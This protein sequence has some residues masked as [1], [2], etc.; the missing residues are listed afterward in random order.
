MSDLPISLLPELLASALTQNA[1]F[2]VAQG[3]TTYRIK[4]S[5]LSPFPQAYGLFTQTGTTANISGVTEQSIIDGGLG[6]L[7]V[8]ANQFQVGD[9]FHAE[10]KGHLSNNNDFLQ[11]RVKGDSVVLADSSSIQ[12]NTSGDDTLFTLDIYFVIRQVGSASIAS[13]LTKGFLRTVKNSNFSVNGYSFE[14]ENNSTFD[15]TIANTLDITIQF[16]AADP[17][18][19]IYTDFFVLN[20]I[21]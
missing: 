6:T 12:Y 21:Y 13:I 10:I 2:A 20:K 19:Y 9:T 15:T 14:S 7:S 4:N 5:N 17:Q 8:G 18:T 16:D 1:E 3:G 11:F